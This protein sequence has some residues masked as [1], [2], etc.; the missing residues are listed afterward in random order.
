MTILKLFLFYR[1]VDT[2][3]TPDQ[4]ADIPTP[5]AT[6]APVTNVGRQSFGATP[7]ATPYN[8]SSS[9]ISTTTTPIV[10]SAAASNKRRRTWLSSNASPGPTTN[11]ADVLIARDIGEC[12]VV[13]DDIIEEEDTLSNEEDEEEQSRAMQTKFSRLGGGGSSKHIRSSTTASVQ[14]PAILSSSTAAV[15]ARLAASQTVSTTGA[16]ISRYVISKRHILKLL[17]RYGL[18]IHGTFLL[19]I[20]R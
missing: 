15:L 10:W 3:Y 13:P 2:F 9:S 14:S 7:F 12:A 5:V 1:F 6:P 17:C 18:T 19:C 8:A 4:D 11:V 16:V 20:L